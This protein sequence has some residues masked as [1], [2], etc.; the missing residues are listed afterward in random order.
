MMVA[1]DAIWTID[2]MYGA[3]TSEALAREIR[4][5]GVGDTNTV[6]PISER[7]YVWGHL[8]GELLAPSSSRDTA[9]SASATAP[10]ATS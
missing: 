10:R 9:L 8:A 1:R 6:F 5:R 4:N 7:V 2:E 3:G